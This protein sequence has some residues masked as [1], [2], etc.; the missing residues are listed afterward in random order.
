MFLCL[1]VRTIRHKEFVDIRLMNRV[2]SVC[3]FQNR[4]SKN[5][6]DI[7]AFASGVFPIFSY[8]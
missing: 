4:I 6:N 5:L 7:E 8:L 2:C 3:D 1:I